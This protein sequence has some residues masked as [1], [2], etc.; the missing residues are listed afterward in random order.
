MAFFAF[1]SAANALAA[2][3]SAGDIE[4]RSFLRAA[5]A[6]GRI[7]AVMGNP[8]IKSK[9]QSAKRSGAIEESATL[10][11]RLSDYIAISLFRLLRRHA[12]DS[13]SRLSGEGL[14]GIERRRARVP[15]RKRAYCCFL[16]IFLLNPAFKK[17]SRQ[18]D[19]LNTINFQKC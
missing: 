12:G 13:R 3:F 15:L 14:R 9:C 19:S 17:K 2:A 18:K 8:K 1:V 10:T 16:F 7:E 6:G 4:A 11:T 5:D